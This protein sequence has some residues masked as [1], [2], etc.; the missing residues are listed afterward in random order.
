MR[1]TSMKGPIDKG[2]GYTVI[3]LLFLAATTAAHAATVEWRDAQLQEFLDEAAGNNPE[4]QAAR[5]EREAAQYRVSPAG[6]LD[7]PMLEG[8]LQ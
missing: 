6:A 7:D 4:I 1:R 3:A 5:S 2:P 8:D